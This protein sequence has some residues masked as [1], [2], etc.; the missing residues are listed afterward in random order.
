ME[1]E[2]HGKSRY[3]NVASVFKTLP[4]FCMYGNMAIDALMTFPSHLELL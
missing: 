3:Q 2:D 4:L 1:V